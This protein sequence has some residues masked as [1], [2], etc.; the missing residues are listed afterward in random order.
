M[1]GGHTGSPYGYLSS[2]EYLANDTWHNGPNM[3]YA[4]EA[5]CAV[6][7]EPLTFVIGGYNGNYLKTIL[8]FNFAGMTWTEKTPMK[9]GRYGHA[10]AYLSGKIYVAGSI[11]FVLAMKCLPI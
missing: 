9:F 5:V 2:M 4:P 8:A 1:A 6:Y 3:P 10:C 11:F 7:V